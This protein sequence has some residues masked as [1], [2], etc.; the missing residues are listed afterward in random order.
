MCWVWLR[1]THSGFDTQLNTDRHL[2][3]YDMRFWGEASYHW[4]SAYVRAR[5]LYTRYESGDAP[6]GNDD[7]WQALRLDQGYLKLDLASALELGGATRLDFYGGRQFMALA[8]VL[9]WLT[10]LMVCAW[11]GPRVT[12]RPPR[13]WR[14]H[15]TTHQISML[16]FQNQAL[17]RIVSSLVRRFQPA[18]IKKT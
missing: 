14:R 4:A 16:L 1:M 7:D 10:L 11:N 17:S 8:L 9:L 6:D 13:F 18:P 5:S 2:Q 15:Y 3:D 12:G